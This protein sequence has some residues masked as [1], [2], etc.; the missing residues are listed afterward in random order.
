M[1]R[2][3]QHRVLYREVVASRADGVPAPRMYSEVIR[4]GAWEDLQ[5]TYYRWKPKRVLRRNSKNRKRERAAKRA[6][7]NM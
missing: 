5:P 7:L 2:H 6:M 4:Y 1:F 3:P